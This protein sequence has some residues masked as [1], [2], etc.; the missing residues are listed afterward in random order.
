MDISFACQHCGAKLLAG[1]PDFG[2][3]V[4]CPVCHNILVVPA[5]AATPGA[6]TPAPASASKEKSH[7]RVVVRVHHDPV[8]PAHTAPPI[9]KAVHDAP[10]EAKPPQEEEHAEHIPRKSDAHAVEI[11]VGWICIIVGVLIEILLPR[12]FLAY[13]PFFAGAVIMGV[14]LL[15]YGKVAHGLVMML[16]TIVP[17]PLLMRQN[18]WQGIRVS[19]T[20]KPVEDHGPRKLVFD[21]KGAPQLV[22][23]DTRVARRSDSYQASSEARP[24]LQSLEAWKAAQRKPARERPAPSEDEKPP[25]EQVKPGGPKTADD[26]YRELLEGGEEI[27]AL[28][29]EDELAKPWSSHEEGFTWQEDTPEAKMLPGDAALPAAVPFVLYSEADGPKPYQPSGL[30]GNEKALS[31]DEKWN[32]DAHSGQ[33][34]MRVS[35]NDILDWVNVVWQ[36][37]KNNWGDLPGGYDLSKATKLTFWAKGDKGREEVEFMVG[38]EQPL[39]S[40]SR[41]TLKV[42]SGKIKLREKWK[43]HSIPL[44][45]HDRSRVISGLIMRI[46]GQEAPVVFYLDDIQFE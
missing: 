30:M 25:E 18:V 15:C 10:A 39:T 45:K 44:E 4:P 20:Q 43:K 38:M 5:R 11:V 46:E 31:L 14:I 35:Y 21:S 8:P 42:S 32:V 2:Q 6:S 16:C 40:V 37:P 26:L 13:L 9:K 1:E 34:C 19:A 36:H 33:T 7:R 17:A 27:P 12:A 28:I 29:P 3:S 41:D 23:A 22:S 24:H